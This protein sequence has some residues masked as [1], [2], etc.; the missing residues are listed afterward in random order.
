VRAVTP[1]T[2]RMPPPHTEAMYDPALSA[3]GP[4]GEMVVRVTAGE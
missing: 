1:G 4:V 2:F 3:T